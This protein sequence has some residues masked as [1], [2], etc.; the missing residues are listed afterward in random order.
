MMEKEARRRLE[1]GARIHAYGGKKRTILVTESG[2]VWVHVWCGGWCCL[3]G[4]VYGWRSYTRRNDGGIDDA[5]KGMFIWVL[6][7]LVLGYQE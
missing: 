6:M 2:C 7:S 4:S 3:L 1:S 5:Q